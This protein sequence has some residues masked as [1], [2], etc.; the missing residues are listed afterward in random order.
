MRN[1]CGNC[2]FYLKPE[3]PRGYERDTDLWRMQVACEVF[4]PMTDEE[5]R[6]RNARF[7]QE[8]SNRICPRCK[9]VLEEEWKAC[10]YCGRRLIS[11]DELL[12][13]KACPQCKRVLKA[14]WKACPYCATN[15][16]QPARSIEY[17]G[18]DKPSSAW[19]LL[20][21]FFGIIGG[22]I[23]YVGVKDEDSDMASNLLVFGII[24]SFILG[25]IGWAWVTS[26]LH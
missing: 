22:L 13:P 24:W 1:E 11:A 17:E 7:G 16:V 10:P 2:G 20:P 23:G 12:L 21:F 14:E 19:Y 15:V 4:K 25:I 5:K 26:L 3:C 9:R 18:L 6:R 8:V